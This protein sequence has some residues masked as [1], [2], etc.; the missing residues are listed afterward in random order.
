MAKLTEPK[1]RWKLQ[2]AK[3]RLSELV[4][5][6]ESEGPQVISRQIGRAHV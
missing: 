2:D 5:L 4:R 1:R 3:A 6:A